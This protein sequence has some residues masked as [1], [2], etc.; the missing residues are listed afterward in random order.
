MEHLRSESVLGLSL[1]VCG[2][3]SSGTTPL[4]FGQSHTVGISIGGGAA[5]QSAEFT[6]GYRDKNI[7]IVPVVREDE[8]GSGQLEAHVQKDV[9]GVLGTDGDALSVLGQF[10]VDADTQEKVVLGK[11]FATGIAARRLADGFVGQLEGE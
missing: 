4:I 9:N 8:S 10:S 1:L 2:C 6:L 5:D 3:V 7:A 11:F